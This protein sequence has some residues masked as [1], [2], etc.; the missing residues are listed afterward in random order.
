MT[1]FPNYD[2]AEQFL[3]V[4]GHHLEALPQLLTLRCVNL[5]GVIY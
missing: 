1:L 5:L 4:L 3:L 2:K